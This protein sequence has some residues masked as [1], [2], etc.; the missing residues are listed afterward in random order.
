MLPFKKIYHTTL[1]NEINPGDLD[2]IK[3]AHA[4]GFKVIFCN[5][6]Y[7]HKNDCILFKGCPY[8]ETESGIRPEKR[9]GHIAYKGGFYTCSYCGFFEIILEYAASSIKHWL[10]AYQEFNLGDD[11]ALEVAL[12]EAYSATEYI[13][14]GGSQ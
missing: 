13:L 6:I 8:C 14:N 1:T 10:K 5:S 2:C 7:S 9:R 4:Q 11:R 12:A 3:E